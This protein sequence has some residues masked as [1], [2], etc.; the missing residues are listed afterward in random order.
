MYIDQNPIDY[1]R[2]WTNFEVLIENAMQH[3]Q[4]KKRKRTVS[5]PKENDT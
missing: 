1:V 2:L 5:M 4:K 3:V